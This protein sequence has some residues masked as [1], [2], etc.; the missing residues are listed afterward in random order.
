LITS[1]LPAK[2]DRP[3][4][5]GLPDPPPSIPRLR[6]ESLH[7]TF[8]ERTTIDE[9]GRPPLVAS[10]NLDHE[11]E[12]A[13]ASPLDERPEKHRFLDI[14]LASRNIPRLIKALG[15]SEKLRISSHTLPNLDDLQTQPMELSGP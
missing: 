4:L 8:G 12:E 13:D 7:E 3:F 15:Q 1:T 11:P 2:G 9:D 10:D 5:H 6:G 14:I